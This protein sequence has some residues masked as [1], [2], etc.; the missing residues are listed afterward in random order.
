MKRSM[1]LVSACL[2]ALGSD[3][4]FAQKASTTRHGRERSVGSVGRVAGDSNCTD[5]DGDGY[6]VGTDCLG[7]DCNDND[8]NINPGK[9]ELCNGKDDN[10]NG[11][12]DEG[13]TVFAPDGTAHCSGGSSAGSLCKIA[14]DCPGGSCLGDAGV[15]LTFDDLPL[16]RQCTAGLGVCLRIGTVVCNAEHTAAICNA[17]AGP[18][19]PAGEGVN[20]P[21]DPTCFDRKDN[22]C[23]GITDH[24][25]LDEN[26]VRVDNPACKTA[27]L[28]DGFDNDNNGLV[29]DGFN[30]GAPCTVGNGPC[31]NAGIIICKPD[32][33][34]GCN[35]SPLPPGVE[36]VPGS[37]RCTDGKDNDCDGKIDLADSGCQAPE[38]C[39]GKDNDGNGQIDEGFDVGASCTSGVGACQRSGIRVCSADQTGTVCTAVAA[40]P[41]PETPAGNLC[42]DGI[43]NDCDGLI[44]LADG[45]CRIQ[46][47]AVSCALLSTSRQDEDGIYDCNN[48]NDHADN[49]SP[50]ANQHRVYFDTFGADGSDVVS[51]E[52]LGIDA[53]GA[54]VQ[55][56]PVKNGDIVHFDQRTDIPVEMST[57]P[58]DTDKVFAEFDGLH[59]GDT[60]TLIPEPGKDKLP[61]TI[62][63]H[64]LILP[65]AREVEVAKLPLNCNTPLWSG[66][67]FGS[68]EI[69]HVDSFQEPHG[70]QTCRGG[71]TSITLKYIGKDTHGAASVDVIATTDKDLSHSQHSIT[72]AAP[73]LRI[74]LQ[75]P[76]STVQ[77]Y[78]AALPFVDVVQ[79][80]GSVS[81]GDNDVPTP[82]LA[83]IP[84]I[85]PS[86]LKVKVGGVD[87][88]AALNIDPARDLPGGP[89]AGSVQIGNQLVGVEDLVVQSAPIDI[90]NANTVSMKLTGLGCGSN[91]VVVE[92][93]KVPAC[94]GRV[95]E[96]KLRYEGGGCP[97]SANTQ[98]DRKFECDGHAKGTDPVRIKVTDKHDRVYLDTGYPATVHLRDTIEVFASAIGREKF[99]CDTIIKI[100]NK[101]NFQQEKIEFCTSC[102]EPLTVGYI[103]GSIRVVGL[104]SS[105]KRGEEPEDDCDSNDGNGAGIGEV[106]VSDKPT[107]SGRPSSGRVSDSKIDDGSSAAGDGRGHSRPVCYE[108]DLTDTGTATVFRIDVTKPAEGE[109]T[110]GGPT[111]VVGSV[112]HGKRITETDINGFNLDVGAQVVTPGD[113]VSTGD[114]YTLNFDINV[115]VTN[116]RKGIAEGNTTGSFDPGSNLLVARAMDE[117]FNTTFDTLTFAVGP[118]VPAPLALFAAAGAGTVAA[119]DPPNFVQRAFVMGINTTGITKVFTVQ[120]D[121][122]SRCIKDRTKR[123]FREQHPPPKKL[124]VDDACDPNVSM[125]INGTEFKKDS[126]TNLE[127]DITATVDP[128]PNQI[129][130]RLDLPPLD[131]RAHFGG[132]CESGCVCAFGGCVCASC[133]TVDVNAILVR[134]NM[135]LAFT[136]TEQ[137]ILQ[138]GIPREQREPLDFDF[139]IGESDP[140]DATKLNGQVDIGCALGFL[141]DIADFFVTVF[142]LGFVDI[143]LDILDFEITGDDMKDRFDSLDGDP[144]DLE[145]V[146]MKNDEEALNDFDSKQRDSKL[147]GCEITDGGM[148]ISVG[149]AFEPKEDKIDPGARPIPGTPLKNAPVPQP[150]ISDFLGRTASE[151]TIAISDDVFNQLFYNMTQTGKLKTEFEHVRELRSFM[152]DDCD[153]ITDDDS[154]RARCIGWKTQDCSA[155][156]ARTC[157]EAS[158]NA[159]ESCV[160][161]A[162]CRICKPGSPNAGDQCAADLSCG[163][164]CTGALAGTACTTNGQC[165][166]VCSA[167]S[168]NAGTACSNSNACGK[169]CV[170]GTDAGDTC[171]ANFQCAGGGSCELSGTC[172]NIGTCGPIVGSCDSD[173]EC[174]DVDPLRRSC[175]IGKLLA[176][177][178]NV[179]PDTQTILKAKIDEAP[180]L[181]I[182]DDPE[183]PAGAG[184]ND[185]CR[186]SPVEVKLHI[187]NLTIAMIADRN[188]NSLVD[189]DAATLADCN[190][191]ELNSD[192]ILELEN[193]AAGTVSTDCLLFKHCLKV[194]VNF[195][196]GVEDH[197]GKPRIK[198]D[199]GGIDRENTGGYQCGGPQ[200]LPELNFFNDRAGRDGSLDQLEGDMRDNTPRMAP[201]GLDLGG[202]I[203]FTLDRILAIRTRPL[204][205]CV[206][207]HCNGGFNNGGTCTSNADCE[208]GYQDYIGLT[209]HSTG[210]PGPNP[211][212]PD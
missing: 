72:S 85:D 9:S 57:D 28:C 171:T 163:Q 12:T 27:E 208:D 92:G 47:L 49:G 87:V 173:G 65:E 184:P 139:N 75:T 35:V 103:F 91:Q 206:A 39:D 50:C 20:G 60:F 77:A 162:A 94:N 123:K 11:Q 30:L 121:S 144:M 164:A 207:G 29:D 101:D 124:S 67:H 160:L 44:D 23:D 122:N 70:N 115:P 46:E 137:N 107:L 42:S 166:G 188:N 203:A 167:G 88:L 15:F 55:T 31:Q 131:L 17:V 147:T 74:T 51:A 59:L 129:N 155:F 98:C 38:K 170:G 204:S 197:N 63:L 132:Y 86:T 79:P 201:D 117:N 68:F 198:M 149:S 175:V 127:L 7:P 142:T 76:T 157:S 18:A 33:T 183:C 212:C 187:S 56:L 128:N 146:K 97:A 40:Q 2:V 150:P 52:I 125:T 71:V 16:G 182:D 45:N 168:V 192:N 34:A 174:L 113:G 25:G 205:N 62:Y 102:A 130:V 19:D 165:T 133:V 105:P 177:K 4:V 108:D 100:F 112:C 210:T 181:L 95:S 61:N 141:L 10:C 111:R 66:V 178:F 80:N 179:G 211:P 156:P 148:S 140:D 58:A 22:D 138:T 106:A 84:N 151:V 21:T 118:I 99:S 193:A 43:D 190:F 196:M 195:S 161:D 48:R 191:S 5:V 158:L 209:G 96:I 14:A 1:V 152:P 172:D 13:F 110:P 69:V 134:K 136:V 82:V 200:S 24:G 90:P 119:A 8:A 93:E 53:T 185:P 202:N 41:T 159:G 194:D 32:G 36:N 154:R 116:L 143:D 26:N 3:V 104:T 169:H 78:C 6:G 73:L 54:V 64:A 126:N 153:T 199:F 120:K 145:F 81:T 186:T 89:F 180:K 135:Y 176:K 114:L 109:V 37:P 83:A 189:G